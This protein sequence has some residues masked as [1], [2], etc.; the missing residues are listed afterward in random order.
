MSE[1]MD[2]SKTCVEKKKDSDD[3]SK[4]KMEPMVKKLCKGLLKEENPIK[5]VEK[6]QQNSFSIL[7]LNDDCL[8]VLFTQMTLPDG[9]QLGST[10]RRLYALY[11]DSYKNRQSLVLYTSRCYDWERYYLFGSRKVPPI[12]DHLKMQKY[13]PNISQLID[14][15]PNLLFLE[16]DIIMKCKHTIPYLAK[17]LN[18]S[19]MATKLKSL[20][21]SIYSG[22][23]KCVR[24]ITQIKELRLPSLKHLSLCFTDEKENVVEHVLNLPIF[25]S[26]LPQLTSFH[27][28]AE[29]SHEDV[30]HFVREHVCTNDQLVAAAGTESLQV[31]L[32][33]AQ[34]YDREDGVDTKYNLLKLGELDNQTLKCITY[35]GISDK[36]NLPEKTLPLLTNLRKVDIRLTDLSEGALTTYPRI[37]KSL[38]ALEYLEVIKVDSLSPADIFYGHRFSRNEMPVLLSVRTFSLKYENFYHDDPVEFFHLEHCFPGLKEVSV[39]FKLSA[40]DYCDYD[41]DKDT[42]IAQKCGLKLARGLLSLG[43]GNGW[44]SQVKVKKMMAYFYNRSGSKTYSSLAN[45]VAGIKD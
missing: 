21:L 37:L 13:V 38:A 19:P 8:L 34:Q 24:T 44:Q 27:I 31:V 18:N 32:N 10:C 5:S 39:F 41:N 25:H 14:R 20:K 26:V 40:C 7:Q 12:T 11:R 4:L 17:A 9:L 3:S 23:C 6:K 36:Y 29:G 15:L 33:T 30:Y 16:I 28:A 35:F 45:L 42:N 22:L 2:D 1:N 43:T